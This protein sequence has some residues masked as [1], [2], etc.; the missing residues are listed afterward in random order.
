MSFK[1]T[2]QTNIIPRKIGFQ[3]VPNAENNI[4]KP[5]KNLLFTI[6]STGC[7]ASKLLLK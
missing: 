7:G 5:S 2:I 6:Y 1:I 4:S 3:G